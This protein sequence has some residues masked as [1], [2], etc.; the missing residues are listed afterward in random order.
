MSLKTEVDQ[1]FLAAV[2][3]GNIRYITLPLGA[4]AIADD[5]AWDELY[6]AAGSPATV[7][8]L[9]GFSFSIASGIVLAE[10]VMFMDVGYGGIDDPVGVPDNILITNW[11]I[12]L[13]GSAVAIGPNQNQTQLL[14]YPIRIPADQADPGS[15][16]AAR[17]ASQDP[18]AAYTLTAVR[19][20]LAIAVGS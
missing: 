13:C 12:G 16:M 18:A 4:I 17:I 19:V 11:P 8:W 10:T 14:P 1:N 6:D 7:H 3:S 2:E 9:C 20:I 15:R 5:A